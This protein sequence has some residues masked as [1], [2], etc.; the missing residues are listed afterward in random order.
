MI[1]GTKICGVS[2]F[3]TLNYILNHPY[4][5]KFI[6]FICNFKKSKRYVSFKNLKSLINIDKKNSIYF[7]S[8][9][10][11]PSDEILEKLKILNF[12]Y[13]QLYD[14]NPE[15]TKLIKKKYNKKIISALCKIKE[16]KQRKIYALQRYF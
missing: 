11:N 16:G 12:D 13:Y 9:L 3:K 1:K 2:D 10:V 5:P 4:P 7:V 8:V 15:R 6:G 14:V